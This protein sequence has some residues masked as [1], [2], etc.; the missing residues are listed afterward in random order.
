MCEDINGGFKILCTIKGGGGG[1]ALK[2]F[3]IPKGAITPP[4]T[5]RF[6]THTVSIS[7][8]GFRPVTFVTGLSYFLD[9]IVIGKLKTVTIYMA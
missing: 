4:P 9:H 8:Q 1:E 7:L 2:V 3:N 5:P 6:G